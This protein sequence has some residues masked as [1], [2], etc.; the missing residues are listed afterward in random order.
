MSSLIGLLKEL[1]RTKAVFS[2]VETAIFDA[3]RLQLSP[4]DTER[5]T[6]QLQAV[7]KIYR[8]PDGREVNLFVKRNGKVDWPRELCFAKNGEFKIAVVDLIPRQGAKKLRARV[9]CVGG[10]VFLI[11]Y[12]MSPKM[13]ENAAQGKWRTECK[14]LNSPS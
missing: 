12:T 3:I 5:W 2:Q 4:N 13:F 10:H 8:S 11:A 7:N 14:I 9:W 1:F 6:K